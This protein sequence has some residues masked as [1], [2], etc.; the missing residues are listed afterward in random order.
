M[1]Y[2]LNLVFVEVRDHVDNDPWQRATEV[3]E[4][5]HDK[6][7]YTSGKN[8]VLHIRVPRRPQSLKEIEVH[9]VL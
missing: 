4:L 1:H 3:Y 2:I 6:G 8:I 9:I 5:V 7:H